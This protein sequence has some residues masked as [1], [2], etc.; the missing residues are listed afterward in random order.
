M[1][2]A[3]RVTHINRKPFKWFFDYDSQFFND[4]DVEKLARTSS[5]SK[6]R[7]L[8]KDKAIFSRLKADNRR[9]RRGLLN[10]QTK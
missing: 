4:D 8:I 9:H 5:S 2:I 1:Q 10:T 3:P 7:M 6:R